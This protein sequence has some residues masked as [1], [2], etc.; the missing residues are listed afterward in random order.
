MAAPAM[1]AA[2][3]H[4]ADLPHWWGIA[5]VRW[6]FVES[7][8]RYS[9]V[10]PLLSA[11]LGVLCIAGLGLAAIGPA[12]ADPRDDVKKASS[13]AD[14]A[15]AILEGATAAA[16]T[17]VRRLEVATAA[18][19]AAR[20]RVAVAKGTVAAAR[21]EA[22]SAQRTATTARTSYDAVAARFRQ[23]QAHVEVARDRVDEIAAVSYMG[24]DIATINLLVNATGP[25]D[26]MDRLDLLDQIMR[27]QQDSV[28]EVMAA[29]FTAR[30]EQDASGL[31]KR[32]AEEAEQDAVD[33]LSAAKAAEAAA[34]NAQRAVLRLAAS[35][36]AALSVA[37]SQRAAVLA[38]YR[39]AR[40]DE[41]RIAASLRGWDDDNPTAVAMSFDGDDLLMPVHG[42]KSSDF[43]QRYDPYYG[44]WQLHAGTDIAAGGGT[45]IHAAADG[46]VSR[47]GWDGGYGNYTCIS[48]GRLDGRRFS[49]C[50]GH[51]SRIL[52]H[53]GE[54][55]SRGEVIGRVGSTGA[56]TGNHLHFE[57][58]FDGEPKNPLNYLPSCLC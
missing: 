31:A 38:N 26:A 40:A 4:Y 52:V 24:G 47:A 53:V 30:T 8:Y 6:L 28:T 11:V 14:R 21:V 2:I 56:S 57:T 1:G 10:S 51:Q 48:H 22:R 29:R 5:G 20:Q 37:R 46:R 36:R 44:V 3:V 35:R 25:Q 13:K 50:Y 39:A 23:A 55:V 27:K 16:R 7:S 12:G 58:R 41:A 42:W 43:G 54:R 32:A 9:R 45:P 33:K 15:E 18:L 19:P 17:A 49:T 34:T